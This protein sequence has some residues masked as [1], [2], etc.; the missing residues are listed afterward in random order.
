MRLNR[1]LSLAGVTSRRKADE[2]IRQGK[3]SIGGEVVKEMGVEVDPEKDVVRVEGKEAKLPERFLY[4]LV[5][6]PRGWLSSVSDDRGRRVVVDLVK[7]KERLYPVGRLDNDAEGLILLTNDGEL[8]NRLTHP[9]WGV[10]RT[11]LVELDRSP[12]EKEIERLRRGVTLAD[13]PARPVRVRTIP[14]GAR[15]LEITL[16]EGRKREL[17]RMMESVGYQVRRIKRVS[18]G[19]LSLGDLEPGQFRFLSFEEV[20]ALREVLGI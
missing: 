3:V 8:A 15:T 12:G 13:G 6:K 4:V 14:A 1:F 7:A 19:P 9:R 16:K 2:L 20:G 18:F 5:H 10:E 11:Y 17:K